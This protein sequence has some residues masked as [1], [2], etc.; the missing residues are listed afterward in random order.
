MNEFCRLKKA[1]Y[2][3]KQFSRAWFGRFNKVM[4]KMKYKQSQREH[5]LF[6]KYSGSGRVVPTLI[7]YF[8][9][10]IVTGNDLMEMQLLKDQLAKEFE[11]KEVGKLKYLLG[12]EVTRSKKGIFVLQ[13]KYILD[14]LKEFGML[15]C[16]S[17]DT[18]LNRIT[19]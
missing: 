13:Q 19:S 6:I 16:K 10:I 1:L 8:D 3:L 7:G 17:I 2:G 12:I 4:L 5:T 15:R 11:I 14:L 18:P 9:D